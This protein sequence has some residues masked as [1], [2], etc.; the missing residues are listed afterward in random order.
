MRG[1][2]LRAGP[3]PGAPRPPPPPAKSE[4]FSPRHS[5]PGGSLWWGLPSASQRLQAHPRP[6]PLDA[7]V[8]IKDAP[9]PD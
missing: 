9:E 5:G 3:G 2:V 6:S 1:A 8:T 7:S 4:P